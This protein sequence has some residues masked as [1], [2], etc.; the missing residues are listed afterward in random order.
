VLPFL[1]GY[2]L[3]SSTMRGEKPIVHYIVLYVLV[4]RVPRTLI[5]CLNSGS[6]KAR[7]CRGMCSESV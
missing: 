5:N 3:T 1:G 6:Q 4:R 7:K 2:C